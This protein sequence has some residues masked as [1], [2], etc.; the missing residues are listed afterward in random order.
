[1][2]GSRSVC[3]LC[4]R[5]T[6]G[7]G[8]FDARFGIGDP[9]RD[10]SFRWFCSLVCQ[11]ICHGRLE[12]IDP[13]RHERAAVNHAVETAGE[14]IESLGRADLMTWSPEEFSTLIE[15]ILTAFTDHLRELG[16]DPGEVPY[17]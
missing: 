17:P 7:F 11:G 2:T 9:R 1:M 4:R 14:Y 10:A 3:A 8:W 15:V 12:M 16:D 6:R 5:G 13:T